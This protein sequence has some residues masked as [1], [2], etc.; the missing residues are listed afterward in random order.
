MP[1]EGGHLPTC[2]LPDQPVLLLASVTFPDRGR[3]PCHKTA[4]QKTR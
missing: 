3:G 2:P 1:A 4:G